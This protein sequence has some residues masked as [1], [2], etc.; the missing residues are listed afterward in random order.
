MGGFLILFYFYRGVSFNLETSQIKVAFTFLRSNVNN[1]MMRIYRVRFCS[2]WY[3]TSLWCN[4]VVYA[5]VVYSGMLYG[6]VE[7]TVLCYLFC[8][9]H[10]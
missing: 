3:S 8:V 1:D 2:L 4:T 5:T 7:C 9:V 6:T 10:Q